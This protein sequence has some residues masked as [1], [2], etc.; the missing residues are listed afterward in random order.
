MQRVTIRIP[1]E[2]VDDV[3]EMVDTG[4]FPNRSEAIRHAVREMLKRE[5]EETRPRSSW[6]TAGGDD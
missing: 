4:Q 6:S 3:D 2:Q 5:E 1:K